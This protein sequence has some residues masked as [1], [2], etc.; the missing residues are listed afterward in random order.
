MDQLTVPESVKEIQEAG[1]ISF[2]RN[3]MKEFC[4]ADIDLNLAEKDTVNFEIH[5]VHQFLNFIVR[6]V[7][8]C[9]ASI[10]YHKKIEK[11]CPSTHVVVSIGNGVVCVEDKKL[12]NSW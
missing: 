1:Y 2:A 12:A 11:F 3:H 4:F 5:D 6:Y 10:Y 8:D 9:K 7:N